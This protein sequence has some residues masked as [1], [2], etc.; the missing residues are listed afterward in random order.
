MMIVL[1]ELIKEVKHYQEKIEEQQRPVYKAMAAATKLVPNFM[2]AK[3]SQDMLTPYIIA[4]VTT[5]L[6]PKEA[7]NIGKSFDPAL[8]AEVAT[9][10]EPSLTAQIADTMGTGHVLKVMQVMCQREFFIKLGEL[11]DALNERLLSQVAQKLKS[12]HDL[13]SIVFHM[14]DENKIKLIKKNTASNLMA[15]VQEDLEQRGDSLA[16]KLW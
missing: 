5:L 12:S 4:Q 2:V 16:L 7:G 6:P 13:A 9:F 1:A 14:K 10:V 15:A 11:S 8:L 3:M